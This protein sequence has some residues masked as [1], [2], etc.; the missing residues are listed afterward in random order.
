MGEILPQ[1]KWKGFLD[2][3]FC[4]ETFHGT[5]MIQRVVSVRHLYYK[6]V[7]LI[8]NKFMFI[9]IHKVFTLTSSWGNLGENRKIPK[10]LL[11]SIS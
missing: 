3:L 6:P 5:L 7:T 1:S 4:F 9:N 11:K 2:I 10:I 8:V